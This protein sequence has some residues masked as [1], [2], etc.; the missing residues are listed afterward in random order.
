MRQNFGK[1]RV[2]HE[3]FFWTYYEFKDYNIYQ[4]RG[5]EKLSEYVAQ[6]YR[7]NLKDI[8]KKIGFGFTGELNFIV[9]N[10]QSECKQSNIDFDNN[11]NG[12]GG[13]TEIA[14]SNIFLHFEGVYNKFDW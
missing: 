2:Q 4:Y 3:E 6:N 5:G 14:S 13:V 12:T 9:Y 8:E 7:E 11:E 10:K 1:S